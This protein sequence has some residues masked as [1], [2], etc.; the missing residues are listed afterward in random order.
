M[1]S[2]YD[3]K[4]LNHGYDEVAARRVAATLAG[5][6]TALQKQ[7]QHTTFA[8]STGVAITLLAANLAGA[9]NV[10]TDVTSTAAGGITATTDTAANIIAAM[11][12]AFVGAT[13]KLRIYNGNATQTMTV[14]GGTGVTISGTATIAGVSYRDF[15]VSV[16]GLNTS[17][18]VTL[19][20]AGTA[21][22]TI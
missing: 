18:A 6:I 9:N 7:A 13:Y 10:S 1:T 17:A 15:V 21:L 2:A 11:P 20:N 12:N 16:T 14:A 5:E 19:T 4:D 22:G 8:G 3:P